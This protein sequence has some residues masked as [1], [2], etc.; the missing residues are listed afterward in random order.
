MA[1]IVEQDAL[2]LLE[3]IRYR[4]TFVELLTTPPHCRDP[5]DRSVLAPAIDGHAQAIVTGD[6]DLRADAGLRE[7]MATLGVQ[8]WGIETFLQ[9]LTQE[10]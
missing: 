10:N 6:D 7:A 8:L 2:D 3:Q 5:K 9:H 1:H 4:A